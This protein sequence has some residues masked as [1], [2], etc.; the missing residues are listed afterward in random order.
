MQKKYA[1]M[2]ILFEK[3]FILYILVFFEYKFFSY[4]IFFSFFALKIVSLSPFQ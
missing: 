1:K 2:F 3:Y 4:D